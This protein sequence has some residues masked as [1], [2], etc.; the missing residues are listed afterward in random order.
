MKNVNFLMKWDRFLDLEE[1]EIDLKGS[2]VI[3]LIGL[4]GL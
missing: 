4:V 1:L 2:N 3:N